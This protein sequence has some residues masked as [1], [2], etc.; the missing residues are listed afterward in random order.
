M[1]DIVMG[2]LQAG[3][4]R[5]YLNR[6]NASFAEPVSI[7]DRSDS[8][9]SLAVADLDGDGDVDIVMGNRG[10]PGAVLLND[11]SG[12]AFRRV[13]FG[14]SQGATYGLAIGDI[15]NDGVPDI[16]AGRSNAPNTLYIGCCARR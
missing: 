6:G 14:D 2:D 13:S 8:V 7:G 15:N 3:G 11:G 5:L 9:Y 10:A 12:R 16:V 4:A 1:L